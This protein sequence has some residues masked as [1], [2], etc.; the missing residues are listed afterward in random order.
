MREFGRRVRSI[1]T[2]P[3]RVIAA[4]FR[5]FD[6]FLNQEPEETPTAEVFSRTFEQP[7]LLVDHLEALRRHLLRAV[8][9]L[10]ITTALSFTFARYILAFLTAPVGGIQSLQSIEVTESIG[11]FMRVSL[12]SGL[13]LALPYILFEVFLF[14]NPALRPTERKMVVVLLP[15]GTLLFITGLAFAYY[16]ML[17]TAL[18]FLV[19]FMGIPAQLRPASYIQFTTGVMFWIGV[20]FEFPLIVYV[21]A[22]IGLV[23][24][25]MLWRGWRIAIVA[26]AILAAVI[27]PTIDPVNMGLVMAPMTV[28]YFLSIGLAAIAQ[29]GRA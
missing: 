6:A 16:V 2:F 12:L 19:N 23:R 9:F 13:V 4:P 24:A 27:T 15:V 26:I 25:D 3:F 1:I 8:V 20:A 22:A 14:L 10:I 29:R 11:A 21:L 5:R 17:P 28:L 7:R 18:P